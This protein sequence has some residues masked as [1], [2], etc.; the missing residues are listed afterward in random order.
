MV[1]TRLAVLDLFLEELGVGSKIGSV[2]DRKLIQKAVY[3]GQLA[4]VDLGYR[5][6]WYVM[7]PYSTSLTRD[8]YQ[9][10]ETDPKDRQIDRTLKPAIAKKLQSISKLFVPPKDVSLNKPEWLELLASWHYLRK[11]SNK[12]EG[13]AKIT[14]KEEKPHLY[15]FVPQADASLRRAG[16]LA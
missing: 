13:D 15:N 8:Y 16:L 9:L 10:N 11:V 4:E 1:D 7:G 2:S 3:L 5:F 14:I 12:A 6:S